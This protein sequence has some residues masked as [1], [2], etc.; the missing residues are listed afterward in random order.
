MS[1]TVEVQC[2]VCGKTLLRKPGEVAKAKDTC[3]L[4]CR[5]ALYKQR[6][7]QPGLAKGRGWNKGM[8]KSRGDALSYGGPR[9]DETKRRI[10]KSVG[11]YRASHSKMES[12][13]CRQCGQQ[14]R[15]VASDIKRGRAY[16]GRACSDSAA[17]TGDDRTCPQCGKAFYA[18]KKSQRRCCSQRCALKYRGETTVEKLG[19]ALLDE[20]GIKHE[21]QATVGSHFIVDALLSAVP[22]VVEFDGDYWHGNPAMFPAPNTVQR[23]NR[24]R[25]LAK[26]GY[27][28]KLGFHC[29]RIWGS[30]L[31]HDERSA[32]RRILQAVRRAGR[33]DSARGI[34]VG[35]TESNPR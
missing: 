29:C 24:Q 20:L 23:K 11:E 1:R 6:G 13:V 3:C 15:A 10:A 18:A 34:C 19:Y 9:S 2:A 26:D 12:V 8:S 27:L 16:C 22:V 31:R 32:M 33:T 28:R 17:R 5:S 25:D 30:E 4:G 35:A 14:F 7:D 21:K